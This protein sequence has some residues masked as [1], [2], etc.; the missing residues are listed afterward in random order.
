MAHRLAYARVNGA[1]PE[2]LEIDHVCR[3]KQCVN[4]LHLEA[5][6]HNENIRRRY[7]DYTHCVNGHEYT[8]ENTYIRTNGYRDC[9][10]CIRARVKK[11]RGKLSMCGGNG[12]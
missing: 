12:A 2:G 10:V 7:A 4:P 3:N 5:V 8:P 1:I 9:R 11:Y 6:T